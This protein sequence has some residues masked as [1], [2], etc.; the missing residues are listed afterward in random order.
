LNE[1][2]LLLKQAIK[3]SDVIG[4]PRIAQINSHPRYAAV[5]EVLAQGTGDY[6][7][8]WTDA[9]VHFYLQWSGALG[10]L[11]RMASRVWVIG[12]RDVAKDLQLLT[13]SPVGQWLVRGEALYPGPVQE[14]H[15]RTGYAHIMEQIRLHTQPGDL[16]LVGAGIL[17]KTYI[18]AAR[19]KGGVALDIGSVIDGWAG[20]TSRGVRIRDSSEFKIAHLEN[21]STDSEMTAMLLKLISATNIQDASVL[22]DRH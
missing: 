6:P 4:V 10:K 2:N 14:P 18:A 9:A 11:I 19:A 21:A 12:C 1:F 3:E 20:I 15:W 13:H 7:V 5:M 17:G 22:G 16:I 8:L